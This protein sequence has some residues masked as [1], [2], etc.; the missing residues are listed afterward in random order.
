MRE[1]GPDCTK[2]KED[3]AASRMECWERIDSSNRAYNCAI[4][5]EF[6]LSSLGMTR[7]AGAA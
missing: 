4:A 1:T 6:G 2:G 5:S 3:D 7:R